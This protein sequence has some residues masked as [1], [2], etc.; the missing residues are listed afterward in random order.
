VRGFL[1]FY[2]IGDGEA[3]EAQSGT[4]RLDFRR[5]SLLS[6]EVQPYEPLALREF[7]INDHSIAS[8]AGN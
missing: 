2:D 4:A 5:V 3:D 6:A 8:R 1:F 7:G